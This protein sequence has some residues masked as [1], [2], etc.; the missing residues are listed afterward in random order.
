MNLK[1]RILKVDPNLVEIDRINHIV[2][3]LQ[4]EGVIVY[5][6]DTF[7][8]IGVNCFSEESIDKIFYLKKRETYKP[9]SLVISDVEMLREVAVDI[10]EVFT[11]IYREFWPGPLTLI[12]K[13]STRLPQSLLKGE[14]TIGV[15]LP[16]HPWLRELIR[17][18]GF[19]LTATSANI[20]GEKEISDPEETIEIFSGKVDLIVNA[21]KTRGKLPSTILDLTSK[22]PEI[23]REGAIPQAM[24][25]KYL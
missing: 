14:M 23:L 7:Y 9:I 4:G 2:K 16:A 6:T 8:G 15:R 13:A 24:L 20:S 12:F 18:A 3:V 10:P 21:G 5:P 1:T 11:T 25:E 17:R 19:P 22:K